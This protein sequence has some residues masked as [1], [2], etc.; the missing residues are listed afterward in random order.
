MLTRQLG[1]GLAE[2]LQLSFEQDVLKEIFETLLFL[3]EL[4]QLVVELLNYLFFERKLK[5]F[6]D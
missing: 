6:R 4:F 2:S 3:G 5:Y 1:L